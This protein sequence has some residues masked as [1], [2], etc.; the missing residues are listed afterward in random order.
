L[1]GVDEATIEAVAR[2]LHQDYVRH[3]REAGWTTDTNPAM[4]TW[5]ELPEGLRDSNRHQA[6]HIATKL[7]ALGYEIGPTGDPA[8]GT[9]SF[10]TEELERMAR[11]EHERWVGE[12]QAAGWA[13]GSVKDPSRKLSPYLVPWES[14]PEEIR[15]H[16]RRAVRAIPRVLAMVG[17]KAIGAGGYPDR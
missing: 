2:A 15:E 7:A 4:V 12:R 9:A 1:N 13:Y 5:E 11:M 6:R 10:S 16:D 8:A 17:L 3:E 14:L